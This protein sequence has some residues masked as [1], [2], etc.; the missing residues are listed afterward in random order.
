MTINN[1]NWFVLKHGAVLI[2]LMSDSDT[3]KSIGFS[4]EDYIESLYDLIELASDRFEKLPI[5]EGGE[6]SLAKKYLATQKACKMFLDVLAPI[7]I[8]EEN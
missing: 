8:M 7:I 1:A 3:E 4:Y 2:D 6:G 5:K